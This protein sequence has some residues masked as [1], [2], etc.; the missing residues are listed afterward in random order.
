M[1]HLLDRRCDNPSH[2]NKALNAKM[3]A[4]A[5]VGI[6]VVAVTANTSVARRLSGPSKM[7]FSVH[8]AV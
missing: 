7:P 1:K 2:A 6:A 5:I 4:C 3:T 8:S